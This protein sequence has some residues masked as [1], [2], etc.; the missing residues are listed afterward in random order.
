MNIL[1]DQMLE[2]SKAAPSEDGLK[3]LTALAEQQVTIEEDIVALEE[4]LKA[5]QGRL[6]FVSEEQIP[7]LM[8]E[9]N[10]SEFKLADGTKI[11]IK[12][13]YSGSLAQSN[14]K[15]NEA[16]AWLKANGHDDIIKNEVAVVFGRGE[17]NKCDRLVAELAERGYDPTNEKTVHG[18]TLKA[19]LKEQVEAGSAIPLD[20]F[21]AYIGRK[22]T[23]DVPKE[24]S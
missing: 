24:K 18:S 16:F 3:R 15:R 8:T 6:K 14:P 7:N 21:K 13:F 11:E 20:L 23:I 2:D 10:I 9:L 12:K 5:A 17:E 19:F 22:A 4:A 1:S